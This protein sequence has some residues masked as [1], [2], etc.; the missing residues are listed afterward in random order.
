MITQMHL[1]LKAGMASSSSSVEKS[2]TTKVD[3]LVP[4][5]DIV[6]N[7]SIGRRMFRGM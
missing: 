1:N 3:M 2:M 4:L 5:E 6:R 7:I